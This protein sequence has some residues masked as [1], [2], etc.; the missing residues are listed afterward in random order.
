VEV[1]R[2]LHLLLWSNF[3]SGGEKG[4]TPAPDFVDRKGVG[5]GAS[6]A[7]SSIPIAGSRAPAVASSS[8]AA[9]SR[10]PSPVAMAAYRVCARDR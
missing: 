3:S 6:G 7:G 1:K 2:V 5:M 4:W 9:W 8:P 10:R